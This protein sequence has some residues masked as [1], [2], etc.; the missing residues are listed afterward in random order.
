MRRDTERG[1]A[2]L[3]E[4]PLG[5]EVALVT[6]ASRGIGRAIAMRFAS[7]GAAV[8]CAARSEPE[9]MRTVEA[10]HSRGGKA[11]AVPTD[12]TVE[13]E[14]AGL[15]E[16]TVADLGGL[17]L[18]ILNAGISPPHQALDEMTPHVWRECIE[19]NLTGV[20]LVMRAAVPHMRNAGGG[21]IIALGSGA[22]LRA[23]EGLGAYAASKAAVSAV[24][25]VAARE[26][27]PHGIAVNE[28]QPGPTATRIHGVPEPEL[29]DPAHPDVV[30]TDGIGQDR[31]IAGEWFKAPQDVASAALFLASLPTHGPTGQI[32]S[33]NSVI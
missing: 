12:V 26:L 30:L 7:A 11:L 10:I 24:V 13:A 8:A 5:G 21:R 33:L 3:G 28:L 6:G 16:R 15:V 9:L 1:D 4:L 31:S 27:R 25:R 14:V 32:L 18:V 19:T 17:S 23:P 22:S 20:F 2:S 29:D